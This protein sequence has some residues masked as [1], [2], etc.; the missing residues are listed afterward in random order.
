MSNG[1]GLTGYYYDHSGKSPD[2]ANL[3]FTRIDP[4]IDF[5]WE[6]ETPDPRLDNNTFAVRWLGQIEPLYSEEYTFYTTSSD[7]IRLWIDGELL[8]D[9]WN[10]QAPTENQATVTLEAGKQYD[11]RIDYHEYLENA[12]SQFEWS[13]TSQAREIVPSSQLYPD[14]LDRGNAGVLELTASEFSYNEDGTSIAAVTV[15]RT[16]GW[17]GEVAVTLN[18]SDETA[19]SPQDYDSTPITVRFADG[20]TTDKVITLPII[21]DDLVEGDET[22]QLTLSDLVGSASI[23][24][25]DSATVTIVDDDFVA[26][27]PPGRGSGLTGY[28]YDYNG[29]VPDFSNLVLTRTDSIVDFNWQN[30]SPSI[31]LNDDSFAVRWQGQIEPRYSEEYTFHTT[32]SD[33]IRVWVDGELLI[34]DWEIQAPTTNSGTITLEAGQK[35]DVRIDYYE[36]LGRAVSQFEWSSLSQKRE[37]VPT[38]QLYPDPQLPRGTLAFTAPE[39]SLREDGTAVLEV[40]VSRTGGSTGTVSASIDLED[41]TATSPED[42]DNTP[43]TVQFDDGDTADKTISI[44]LIDDDL[45]ERDETLNL[46]LNRPT[47]GATLGTQDTATVNIFD[48]D[49]RPSSGTGLTAYYYDHDGRLPDFSNRVLTRTDPTI[50]FNWNG[51]APDPTLDDNTFAVQWFGQI[52]PLY[53]EDYTF[54]TTSSDGIRLWIDG[55]PLIDDWDIQGPTTN[56]ATVT[57]EAG[58]KYDIRVDYYEYLGRAVSQLEWSSPSQRQEIVPTSQLYPL[59]ASPGVLEFQDPV[60]RVNEDGT[61]IAA[62]TV[63]RKDGIEGEVSATID[64]L[65]RSAVSPDDYDNTPI[66]VRFADGDNQPITVEIPIKDDDRIEGDEALILMLKDAAGRSAT[67]G[68]QDTAVLNIVDNDSIDASGTGLT[69]QYF[70]GT[71]FDRWVE[72]RTDSTIDFDWGPGKAVDGL[73]EDLYSVRWTGEVEPRFTE[74]YRFSTLSDDGVRLW[75]NDEL[76]IDRWQLQGL[77][78]HAGTIDLEAGQRYDIKLEYFENKGDATAQLRWSSPSQVPEIIPQSQLYTYPEL[79]VSDAEALEGQAG[80]TGD[81]VFTLRLSEPS[82][83]PVTVEYVTTDGTA[84]ADV[85]YVATSGTVTFDPGVVEETVTVSLKGDGTIEADETLSLTLQNPTG[86]IAIDPQ[87]VGTILNDDVSPPGRNLPDGTGIAN[88]RDYGATGDGVTDDTAAILAAMADNRAVYFPNGTYLVSDTLKWSDDRRLLMQG[89]SRDGTV[90]KLADDLDSFG[91]PAQPKPLVDTFLGRSTGQAF[92]NS[93]FDLTLDVGVGNPGAIGVSFQNNNQGGLRDVTIRSSDPEFQ[94]HT[95]LALTTPWPGPSLTKNVSVEGFNVGIMTDHNE[96]SNVFENVTLSNQRVVGFHNE[97]NISTFYNL[98]SNNSVPAIRNIDRFAIVTLVDSTLEGGSPDRSAVEMNAGNL[99]ARNVT[100]SGYAS[101]LKN[102]KVVVPGDTLDEYVSNRVHSAFPSAQTSLNLPVETMPDLVYDDVENWVNVENFGAT[103][104]DGIDDTAAIQAALDTGATTVYFPQGNYNINDTLVVGDGVQTIT[105]LSYQTIF[106]IGDPLKS[107]DKPVFQFEGTS[108]PV[109]IERFWGNAGG[110]DFYWFE[111]ATTQPLTIRNVLTSS[112]EAYRNSVTGGK[113]F[114][115]D[116]TMSGWEFNQQQVWG[117]QVNTELPETN[118][119][120]NGSDVWLLG[121]KTE[122]EG[123]VLENRNGGRTE[124]LG[125]LIYPSGGGNRIPVDRPAFIN[126]ESQLSIAGMGESRYRV[127]SYEI[128][129]ED[130]RDGVTEQ[131][132]NNFSFTQRGTGI[133]FPLYASSNEGA[134]TLSGDINDNTLSGGMGSDTISGG[135]GADTFTYKTPGEGAD[136]LVDFDS[137]DTIQVSAAGF[138]GGLQPGVVQRSRGSK[139]G[140]LVS[141]TNAKPTSSNPTFLY[142]TETGQL[143]FD[144][145]GTAAGASVTLAILEGAP[146]LTERQIAVVA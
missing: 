95:G 143:S 45:L 122:K 10:I 79:T 121:L 82:N 120:N 74:T 3:V 19:A 124:I 63:V 9:D 56:R 51:G 76:I 40:T 88:V 7:G 23:G 118:I 48:N 21:D 146:T 27:T 84:E 37:I 127:G 2:F 28:Y 125:G 73:A 34:D 66:S 47:G 20:D 65:D 136:V 91:N 33:G 75:V 52:E 133:L 114:I 53:S 131:I 100:T 87:A 16:G 93:I 36:Y 44:P 137:D 8:I 138:G 129:V 116:V 81:L 64:F 32:S 18:L 26:P 141:G 139:T 77:T 135:G 107:Q 46:T 126:D 78:E 115:E 94:G 96:Y 101:A 58:Q 14:T 117:R 134:E 98:T 43:I 90:I 61:S 85:D 69:G 86:S 57:L 102:N 99:Y 70:E 13:S 11:I 22:L 111:Q 106:S 110:G 55:K 60:F 29:A 59:S 67:I 108:A 83:D 72:T 140:S 31:R 39:F 142:D 6:N 62:V 1:I 130:T 54:Y 109:A 41:G 50:D 5:N 80:T 68:T 97:N 119:I 4:T 49:D 112:G 132:L 113:V 105:G 30:D 42:Y 144:I 71:T 92:Q 123:S 25:Q 89:E 103:P 145:D 35:Y 104:S 128:L 38:S 12:V 15:S 17:S 24:T